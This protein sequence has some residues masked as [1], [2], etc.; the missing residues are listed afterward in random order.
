MPE[1]IKGG[2][3]SADT[4]VPKGTIHS[5]IFW[6]EGCEM[7]HC[8]NTVLWRPNGNPVWTFNGSRDKP[9]FTPSIL[10]TVE[11]NPR[12]VCHS[13]ITD[14]NMQFLSDSWHK[15]AGQTIPLRATTD[16]PY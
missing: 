3:S 4:L 2:S 8:V 10:V 6:C 14:G 11:D 15:L 16:W 13:Y 9:T 5:Y 1:V 7:H 12:R